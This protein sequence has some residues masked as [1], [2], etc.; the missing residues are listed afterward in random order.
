MNAGRW[1][2]TRA[3]VE[4]FQAR[5]LKLARATVYT[6]RTPT[7]NPRTAKKPRGLKQQTIACIERDEPKHR[8]PERVISI[9][10]SVLLE[11][12]L[13]PRSLSKFGWICTTGF[14]QPK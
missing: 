6:R 3:I 1:R 2:A 14:C 7:P 10:S 9:A 8:G 12:L 13:L 4:T 5:G 11:R